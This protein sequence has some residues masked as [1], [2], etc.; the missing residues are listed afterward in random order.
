MNA[1][2][3]IWSRLAGAAR[4]RLRA[5]A[6]DEDTS[7]LGFSTRVAAAWREARESD[8]R[9]ELWQRVSWRGALASAVLCLGVALTQRQAGDDR[10]MIEAPDLEFPAIDSRS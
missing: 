6:A 10:V 4:A 9:L 7:P 2:D 5:T 3:P 1:P 8:R